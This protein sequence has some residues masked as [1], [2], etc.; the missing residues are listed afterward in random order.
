MKGGLI[1]ALGLQSLPWGIKLMQ[2][3]VSAKL[4]TTNYNFPFGTLWSFI[5][6]LFPTWGIFRVIPFNPFPERIVHKSLWSTLSLALLSLAQTS[7]GTKG[8]TAK[9]WMNQLM[10]SWNKRG[11]GNLSISLLVCV[12]ACYRVG[13]KIGS[14]S[15]EGT[16]GIFTWPLPITD[17]GDIL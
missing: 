13:Q 6:S 3:H 8:R 2:M 16:A 1:N 17:S 15:N 12:W 7:R 5:P 9:K 11:E 14:H 10:N 4:V